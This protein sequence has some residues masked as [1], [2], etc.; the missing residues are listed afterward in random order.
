MNIIFALILMY[1]I[2]IQLQNL[3]LDCLSNESTCTSACTMVRHLLIAFA[4]HDS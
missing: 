4:L 2:Y 1:V 3:P